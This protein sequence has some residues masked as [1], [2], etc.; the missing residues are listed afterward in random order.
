[1]YLAYNKVI[2]PKIIDQK[3]E[4]MEET[5]SNL[6]TIKIS[7]FFKYVRETSDTLP[8]DGAL[9]KI[10][11]A[12]AGKF[13]KKAEVQNVPQIA[14]ENLPD[15]EWLDN[16]HAGVKLVLMGKMTPQSVKMEL[17]V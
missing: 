10:L 13:S 9:K 4:L 16:Y 6:K 8:T 11:L 5:L 1:M 7:A 14:P 3:S 17:G 2:Q 15:G 12:N